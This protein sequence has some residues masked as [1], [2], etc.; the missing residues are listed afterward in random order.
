MYPYPSSSYPTFTPVSTTFWSTAGSRPFENEPFVAW[1]TALVALPDSALPAVISVSYGDNEY[2]IDPVYAAQMEVL[3]AKLCARGS[4]IIYA[5]GDGGV[6]GG[7][8][9]PC[10]NGPDGKPWFA[11][12]FPSGSHYVTSVGSTDTSYAKVRGLF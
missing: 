11:P 6:S 7:Q 1:L 10:P 5:S 9:E 12:T 8:S 2:Q 4:S 3:F